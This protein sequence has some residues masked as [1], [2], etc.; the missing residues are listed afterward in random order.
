MIQSILIPELVYYIMKND[1]VLNDYIKGRI[2]PL[3]SESSTEFPYVAYSRTHISPIY[4]KNFH[5]EDSVGVEILSV[6]N[7]YLESLHIANRVRELFEC[8]KLPGYNDLEVTQV[9]VSSVSESY[10]YEADAFI[11][12]ITFDFRVQ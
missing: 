9:Y 7:D 12:R 1:S 8:Q 2:Y 4:T 5:T 6:S 11:Q 3:V 10:D